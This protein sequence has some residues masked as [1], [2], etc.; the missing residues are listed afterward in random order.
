[1][2]NRRRPRGGGGCCAR[3]GSLEVVPFVYYGGKKG[4]AHRYPPPAFG[5]IVEPF[6]GSAGYALAWATPATRVVLIEK[7]PEVIALWRRLLAPDARD[8]LLSIPPQVKGAPITEPIVGLAG[9]SAGTVRKRTVTSRMAEVWPMMRRRVLSA[10]PLIAHWEV[11]EGDY[12]E[13]PN[14]AA[15]WFVDPP[16]SPRHDGREP[17]IYHEAGLDYAELGEWC[18]ARRGQVIVCEQEGADWLPF[19]P[20]YV[21]HSGLQ[22]A[23]GDH[24]PRVEMIWSR[25]PGSVLPGT[26][27][28]RTAE[29]ARQERRR[30]RGRR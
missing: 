12:R 8:W 13:A 10:L 5:T 30:V 16:Y 25:S 23:Q 24:P 9:A 7:D 18:R 20:L 19:R 27:R 11:I 3:V 15:T 17:G 21:Q 4:S 14:I 2:R 1:M 6:A 28:A 26:P 22:G 29:G